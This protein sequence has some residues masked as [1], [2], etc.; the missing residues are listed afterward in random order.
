[1][2]RGFRRDARENWFERLER[3]SQL[4]SHLGRG[5]SAA[6]PL[7]LLKVRGIEMA[8]RF[9]DSS[10]VPESPFLISADSNA[11]AGSA[12]SATGAGERPVIFDH[13]VLEHQIVHGNFQVRKRGHELARGFG[14]RSSSH[15][16]G[17]AIDRERSAGGK[18]FRY[19]SRI[20]AAPGG[21]VTSCEV[22][23][24]ESIQPHRRMILLNK[25]ARN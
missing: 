7:L 4:G 25:G 8:E 21:G 5:F 2:V 9:R 1:M 11:M 17:S 18:K 12:R 23:N 24:F 3:D 13:V 20:L 16:G 6:V 22:A 19:R 14:Y 10:V 15:R